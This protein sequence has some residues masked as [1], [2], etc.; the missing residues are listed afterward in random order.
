MGIGPKRWRATTTRRFTDKRDSSGWKER[1]VKKGNEEK[2]NDL[3]HDVV[4]FGV[5]MNWAVLVQSLARRT[6]GRV[7]LEPLL[8]KRV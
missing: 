2:R 6:G 1:D 7:V 4:F 8:Q 5:V 3:V